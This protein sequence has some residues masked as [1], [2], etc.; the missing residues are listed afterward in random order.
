[1]TF[2]AAFFSFYYLLSFLLLSLLFQRSDG[3]KITSSKLTALK[4]RTKPLTPSSHF[5]EGLPE[6][7]HRSHY[8]N[9]FEAA[10]NSG[11][12]TKIRKFFL[13]HCQND[14]IVYQLDMSAISPSPNMLIYREIRGID[15]I[16]SYFTAYMEVVPDAIQL[17]WQKTIKK[18]ENG[19]R[20][21]EA[22]FYMIGTRFY[23]LNVIEDNQLA[24]EQQ[25]L[26]EAIFGLASLAQA[27]GS[28]N[29]STNDSNDALA[30]TSTPET[31]S[32]SNQE[33]SPTV[34]V[35]VLSAFSA[36]KKVRSLDQMSILIANEKVEFA[37]GDRLALPGQFRTK[38]KLVL[39][40]ND[41]KKLYR[42]KFVISK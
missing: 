18:G 13:E 40:I 35:N 32:H 21:I 19:F 14:N 9:G 25:R 5:P 24:E 2:F 42:M 36:N 26:E 38:G 11:V 3:H 22:V 20:E 29:P 41:K 17:Y 6:S 34:D 15:S 8:L 31:V 37:K 23:E 10:I 1:M 33:P 39:Y 16:V 30:F 27:T 7:I 12:S 28:V 4:K